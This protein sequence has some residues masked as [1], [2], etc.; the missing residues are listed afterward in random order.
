MDRDCTQVLAFLTSHF[1]RASSHIARIGEGAWSQCFGFRCGDQELVIRFGQHV[2]DF[3]KD[4]RASSYRTPDLPIPDVLA[5]GQAFD[6]YY[7]IS[8]RVH[9]VPLE[10]LNAAQWQSIVP[11]LAAALEAMRL[12]DVSATVGFGGWGDAGDAPHPRWSGHLLTVGDDTPDRRTYGWRGRLAALPQADAVFTWGFDR[13]KQVATDSVPRC[14]IHS[15]LI[16]RNVLV[17]ETS[18]TGVFDWGCACYGDHL[19]DLAWFE[20][21]AP[22]FPSLNIDLLRSELERRW[23]AVGYVLHQREERLMA[24]YLHIGL[25]HLAYNAHLGDWAALAATAERMQALVGGT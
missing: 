13:L 9:G 12:A 15:D 23:R 4:Q 24:C 5:I 17:R 2:D 6:G 21:W 14:L 8:T 20:F 11:P 19:Y 7:A 3:R 25:D 16:N 18:I 22:W 1:D 10:R